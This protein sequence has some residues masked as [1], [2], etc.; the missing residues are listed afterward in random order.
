MLSPR[1]PHHFYEFLQGYRWLQNTK[2]LADMFDVKTMQVIN[3]LSS[4]GVT[5]FKPLVWDNIIQVGP[6]QATV[7]DA[8]I[9]FCTRGPEIG[10]TEAQGQTVLDVVRDARYPD[11]QRYFLTEERPPYTSVRVV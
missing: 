9:F 11:G 1:S 2:E 5:L 10:L 3:D 6:L 7:C 8:E 4:A